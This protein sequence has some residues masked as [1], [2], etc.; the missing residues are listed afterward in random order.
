MILKVKAKPHRVF[1]S[2]CENTDD[3]HVK[4]GT[5]DGRDILLIQNS[6]DMLRI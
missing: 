3:G 6:A 5:P 1:F 4:S 2:I